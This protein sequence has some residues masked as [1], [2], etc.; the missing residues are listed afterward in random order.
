[1]RYFPT[2]RRGEHRSS[3]H[4][5]DSSFLLLKNRFQSAP[6]PSQTNPSSSTIIYHPSHMFVIRISDRD[7][8]G[9]MRI[10]GGWWCV[11]GVVAQTTPSSGYYLCIP[12]HVSGLWH[13]S[14]WGLPPT[15]PGI[16]FAPIQLFAYTIDPLE[17]I[18]KY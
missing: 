9:I 2:L 5:M 13:G 6:P 12:P 3:Q 14:V 15:P 1:M 18:Y 8:S 16:T 11:P 4:L 10:T 7:D 17:K